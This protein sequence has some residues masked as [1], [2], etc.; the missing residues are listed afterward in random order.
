MPTGDQHAAIVDA[1]DG[2]RNGGRIEAERRRLAGAD[3]LAA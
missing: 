2:D 3:S 1:R